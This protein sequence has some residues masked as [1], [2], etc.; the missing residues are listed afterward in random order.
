M[1]DLFRCDKCGR[2]GAM[3]HKRGRFIVQ[4]LNHHDGQPHVSLY[5]KK[6]EVCGDCLTLLIESLGGREK[7]DM[8]EAQHIMREANET[9]SVTT[10]ALGEGS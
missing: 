10:R 6:A 1:A 4:E 5:N 8:T 2:T 9:P 3:Q 7:K